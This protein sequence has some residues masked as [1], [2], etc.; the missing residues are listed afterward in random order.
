MIQKLRWVLI[1]L[2]LVIVSA[3]VW[4]GLRSRAAQRQEQQAVE[5]QAALR[6]TAEFLKPDTTS[7][8][9]FGKKAAGPTPKPAGP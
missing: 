3:A 6:K 2:V 5:T 8:I 7:D 4:S 9:R 1:V